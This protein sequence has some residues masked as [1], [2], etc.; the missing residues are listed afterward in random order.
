MQVYHFGRG[1]GS[2][3]GEGK[4]VT[5][6]KPS[7]FYTAEKK[8]NWAIV[9][10]SV[11]KGL[12]ESARVEIHTTDFTLPKRNVNCLVP[13]GRKLNIYA[14]KFAECLMEELAGVDEIERFELTPDDQ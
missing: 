11:A 4:K 7:I 9:P 10:I 12:C 1:G 13:K 8:N 3:D 14:V 6:K 5:K 2:A